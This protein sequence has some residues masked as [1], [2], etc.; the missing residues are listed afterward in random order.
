MSALDPSRYKAGQKITG[1][2]SITE[3]ST[4]KPRP[5]EE[6]DLVNIMDDI[7]RYAEIGREDMAVLM[8]KSRDTGGSGKAGIGT[9]RTRGEIIKKA[10]ESG[11]LEKYKDKKKTFIRPTEKA[12]STYDLLISRP[13]A[14]VLVSPETTAKWE[15]GLKKIENGS[16]SPEKFIAMVKDMVA[17]VTSDLLSNPT[18]QQRANV[19]PHPKDGETCEKCNK[20]KLVTRLVMK[21]DSKNYGKRFVVCDS[22]ECGYFGDFID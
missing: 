12:V 8:A 3:G 20:G 15:V 13:A 11:F 16:F 2:A 19:P 14:K 6:G 7:G 9:A 17:S 1:V 22:K 18:T 10:F 21:K 5:F 4:R